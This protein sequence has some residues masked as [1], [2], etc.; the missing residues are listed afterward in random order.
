MVSSREKKGEGQKRG[1]AKKVLW[2]YM[3]FF[4]IK[5]MLKTGSGVPTF[6]TLIKG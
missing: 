5:T 2:D 3:K 1:G 4:L 6:S